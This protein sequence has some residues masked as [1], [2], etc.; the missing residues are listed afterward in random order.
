MTSLNPLLLVIYIF[1]DCTGYF[2]FVLFYFSF[3]AEPG[4]EKPVSV[5]NV[6]EQ[7]FAINLTKGQKVHYGSQFESNGNSEAPG[8]IGR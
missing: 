7:S 1:V 6:D 4:K 5:S 8:I 2:I 3:G